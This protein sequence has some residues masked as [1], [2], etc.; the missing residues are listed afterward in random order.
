M[1]KSRFKKTL[2][3]LQN[4]GVHERLDNMMIKKVH[5]ANNLSFMCMG[6]ATILFLIS[7]TYNIPLEAKLFL[8]CIGPVLLTIPTLNYFRKYRIAQLTFCL[9]ALAIIFSMCVTLGQSFHFQYVL[10]PYLGLPFVMFEDEIGLKK[11]ILSL[12]G[13]LLF[14]YLD[15][16]F[17]NFAPLIEMTEGTPR[18]NRFLTDILIF[19]IVFLL[20][21]FFINE[22]KSYI[23]KLQKKQDQL[24]DKNYELEH[25]TYICSHNLSEPLRTTSSFLEFVKRE[26]K[27]SNKKLDI[28]FN[29]IKDEVEKMDK[30]IVSLLAYSKL[31]RTYEFEYVNLNT[32]LSSIKVELKDAIAAQNVVI[33]HDTFP[34]IIAIPSL[35]KKLFKHLISNSIK[36]HRENTIPKIT[37]TCKEKPH[38][39][40]FSIKDNGIG[41]S[42][43]NQHKIFNMFTRLH[44]DTEYEGIG[45][46]LTFCKKIIEM[47]EGK[48]QVDSK[49]DKGS[50]FYFTIKKVQYPKALN[51]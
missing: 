31:S 11:I 50:E 46:G 14:I 51:Y 2:S 39:W 13:I 6:A 37:I 27:D 47:H 45:V 41:I 26:I 16:H 36:Y 7:S 19:G 49:L 20:F 15:W 42:D 44:L 29:Y 12:L 40:K 10:L 4:I 8:G 43:D 33:D 1:K 22:N 28:Y 24:V 9:L 18:G 34:E 23:K 25:F 35:I 21:F 32:T 17:C 5:L 38:Y 3:L 30:M 48:I